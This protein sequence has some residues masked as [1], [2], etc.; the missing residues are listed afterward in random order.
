M[1]LGNCKTCFD[2]YSVLIVAVLQTEEGV[3]K[4]F[5]EFFLQQIRHTI[6][7]VA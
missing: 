1:T 3:N 6:F 4:N 2:S 7:S 5:R